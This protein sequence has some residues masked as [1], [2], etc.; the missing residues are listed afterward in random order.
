MQFQPIAA[1]GAVNYFA[2]A[3]SNFYECF[4]RG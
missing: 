1:V 2:A 4:E 3:R